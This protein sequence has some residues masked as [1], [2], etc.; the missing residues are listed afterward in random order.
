MTC[1]LLSILKQLKKM[2]Y[3]M[4]LLNELEVMMEKEYNQMVELEDS[5]LTERMDVVQK[6][7]D[8]GVSRWK[9]KTVKL[10]EEIV[11]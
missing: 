4:G 10:Q 3:K 9:D 7:I 2:Q 6:A 5:L 1:V 8:G 11:L